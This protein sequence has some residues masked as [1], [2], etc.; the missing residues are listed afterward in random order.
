MASAGQAVG[1]RPAQYMFAALHATHQQADAKA[2]ILAAAQ[3]ALAGT[4]G[5]WTHR[6]VL[7]WEGGGGTGWFAGALL[8][9]FTGGL[10]GGVVSLAAALSPRLLRDGGVNRYSF[11]HLASGPDILPAGGAE[12]CGGASEGSSASVSV[13]A[14][15]AAERRELSLTVR[16][17]ARVAVRKYRCLAVAVVCTAVMGVAAGLGVILPTPAV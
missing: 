2:G 11:L 6:A 3:A 13:S 14:D 15:E 7:A 1:N 4:A 10:I 16:F 8:V 12:G 9:L 17:L 5:G